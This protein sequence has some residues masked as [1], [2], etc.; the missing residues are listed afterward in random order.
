MTLVPGAVV[1]SPWTLATA[2]FVETTVFEFVASLIF[3]PAALKY[4]ERLWGSVEVAK[5]IG[6]VLVTSNALA[7]L[8]NWL[9]FIVTRN[10]DLFL[11]VS[12][13]ILNKEKPVQTSSQ[14]LSRNLSLSTK[15]KSSASS[16]RE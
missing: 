1:Y 13:S 10:A 5:F 8:L 14:W 4:L 15:C 9:E 16:R 7:V 3:V 12:P 6:L 11:Y 2:P